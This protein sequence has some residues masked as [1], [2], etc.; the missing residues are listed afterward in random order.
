MSSEEIH[1]RH[2]F[3]KLNFLRNATFHFDEFFLE[4]FLRERISTVPN[5][6]FARFLLAT[7]EDQPTRGFTDKEEDAEEDGG[8]EKV[9]CEWNAVGEF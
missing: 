3:G 7:L 9:A 1:K 2:T 4:G 8:E 6:R 5:E